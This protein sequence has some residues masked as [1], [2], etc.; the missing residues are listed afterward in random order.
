MYHNSVDV[1]KSG[2]G[3]G[4]TASKSIANECRCGVLGFFANQVVVCRV[5]HGLVL[6]IE[7]S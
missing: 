6:L 7:F 3:A 4:R 2:C 1:N 5:V